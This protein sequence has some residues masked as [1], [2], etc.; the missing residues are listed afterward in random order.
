MDIKDTLKQLQEKYD[1]PKNKENKELRKSFV[2][3]TFN[4]GNT[5]E[6]DFLSDLQ[7]FNFKERNFNILYKT[8]QTD[9]F[10]ESDM[11]T[12]KTLL[13][14]KGTLYSS[15]YYELQ[16]QDNLTY[17][18]LINKYNNSIMVSTYDQSEI[19]KDKSM[20]TYYENLLSYEN[21]LVTPSFK[22]IFC[23]ELIKFVKSSFNVSELVSK[24]PTDDPVST[25]IN[26]VFNLATDICSKHHLEF[27]SKKYPFMYMLNSFIGYSNEQSVNT[28]EF[29]KKG[30]KE[31]V[32]KLLDGYTIIN[33]DHLDTVKPLFEYDDSKPFNKELDYYQNSEDEVGLH[34]YL[35]KTYME[36]HGRSFK[37]VINSFILETV[38]NQISINNAKLMH[39]YFYKNNVNIEKAISYINENFNSEFHYESKNNKPVNRLK[40]KM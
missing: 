3:V 4:Q 9:L 29:I 6:S 2:T 22:E 33:F 19:I 11:N 28:L 12:L 20:N 34:F 39:E 25:Y 37:T 1:P 13:T 7:A 18:D 32:R 21:L 16:R 10:D 35:S 14:K 5:I 23:A 27:H 36:Q 30:D 31:V 40:P 15:N 8:Y 26:S 24:A 17:H 38:V